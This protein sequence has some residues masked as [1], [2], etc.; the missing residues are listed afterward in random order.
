VL[1]IPLFPVFEY[2]AWRN[3]DT[4][5]TTKT[6]STDAKL[7][8]RRI[9]DLLNISNS[10]EILLSTFSLIQTLCNM[11]HL[12]SNTLCTYY[13][14]ILRAFYSDF[15]DEIVGQTKK[16]RERKIDR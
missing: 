11:Q 5:M 7:Q 4:A 10:F 15:S 16:K 8:K 3:S 6:S 2:V 13:Q 14:I 9:D 12:S 1:H